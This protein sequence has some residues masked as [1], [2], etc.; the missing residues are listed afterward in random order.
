MKIFKENKK[1]DEKINIP[2]Y[3]SLSELKQILEAI[4]YVNQDSIE[5]EKKNYFF[6]SHL[7]EERRG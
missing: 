7:E 2:E 3:V 4:V 1:G 6:K 5:K